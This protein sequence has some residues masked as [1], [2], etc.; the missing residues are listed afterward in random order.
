MSL[1]PFRLAF[2]V[3]FLFL[4]PLCLEV[5]SDDAVWNPIQRC[6]V[7]PPPPVVEVL[8]LPP[9]PIPP[10]TWDILGPFPLGARELG[11]DPLEA[12]GGIEGIPRGGDL[13]YPSELADG[14]R[15]GWRE[16][17]AN[18]NGS[19]SLSFP[20]IRWEPLEEAHGTAGIL[21][22]G[23]ALGD[24]TVR[25][26]GTYLARC[27]STGSFFVDHIRVPGDRYGD[28]YAWFPVHLTAGTHT[29]R[30]KIGGLTTDHF[31]CSFKE[32]PPPLFVLPGDDTLPDILEG[33][34]VSDWLSIPLLNTTD[35]WIRGIQVSLEDAPFSL[36]STCEILGRCGPAP[37]LA[38]GQAFPLVVRLNRLVDEALS[39]ERITVDESSCPLTFTIV[40]H[41]QEISPLRH[42]VK[43]RCR[44]LD[45][46]FKFTFLGY[47]RSVQYAGA[48]APL[49][50]CPYD[51]NGF[52]EVWGCPVLLSTHGAG[53]RAENKADVYRSRDDL[54]VLT[55]TGR[56]RFGY[57]WEGPGRLNALQ[58]LYAL[59]SLILNRATALDGKK[60]D[61]HRILFAGHSMG[62]HGAMSLSLRYP[63]R[64]LLAAPAA[65]WIKFQHYLPYFLRLGDSFV[66]PTLRGILESAISEHDNDLY[67]TNMVG[68][69]F[70]GR[71]GGDDD[72]VPPWHLRRMVRILE[73]FGVDATLSEIPGKGHWWTGVADDEEMSDF[74][75]RFQNGFPPSPPS[76]TLTLLN[77]ASMESKGGVSVNQLIIPYRVGRIHANQVGPLLD[78]S[79]ENIRTMT[80]GGGSWST[81]N[82]LP[83][84]I[85]IDGDLFHMTSPTTFCHVQ[86]WEICTQAQMEERKTQ[87]GKGR[88]GPARQV[89]ERPFLI[90][91]G[92]MGTTEETRSRLTQAVWLANDWY[93]RSRG[94]TSVQPDTAIQD[95]SQ[96]D[97]NFILV[98]GPS[99]NSLSARLSPS[100]PVLFKGRHF[101]VGDRLFNTPQ[102]GIQFLAPIPQGAKGESQLALVLAGT[103]EE[104]FR[105]TFQVFP[106]ASGTTI[107]DYLVLGSDFGW[108]GA[109]GLLGAGF[110]DNDWSYNPIMG[111][112][113]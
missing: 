88:Y 49:G 68:I 14:G 31:H 37:D 69:P 98:G 19:L 65:G 33:E 32:P 91:Y 96:W 73:G 6:Y 11:A 26:N 62:G 2:M 48:R 25:E 100:F 53:V 23:W 55:P 103:D 111:T 22:Q 41:A 99:T 101:I 39:R 113:R 16:V 20:E 90:V 9:Y 87:R 76:F 47:D 52:P 105:K 40:V 59:P 93:L 60:G 110:W 86:S 108:L 112:L 28:G 92:T 42:S 85:Q 12:Y 97:E 56:R 63:D 51:P 106:S 18:E 95:I 17:D 44:T 35:R 45:Q 84:E 7:S 15:V 81:H 46:S 8:P 94:Q 38:P 83:R 79:T 72:N 21:F 89:L 36:A 27:L 1:S 30:V 5:K 64:A 70:L 77:P 66:D 109:G 58:A 43:L 71:T 54:W 74:F 24:F 3:A 13:T 57:D 67:A 4:L 82:R 10:T 29:I 75:S 61:P 78:L 102:T 80:F 50:S 107:P 104:G 34:L